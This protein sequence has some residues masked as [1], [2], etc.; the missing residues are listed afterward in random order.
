ML[1]KHLGGHWEHQDNSAPSVLT[2]A[3]H[4]YLNNHPNNN[5]TIIPRDAPS[6]YIHLG[7]PPQTTYNS[8][9]P[10]YMVMT[11][12]IYMALLETFERLKR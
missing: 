2:D 5:I 6:I 1:A 12:V 7:Q 4:Q 11:L 9:V 3:V 10:L 8:L